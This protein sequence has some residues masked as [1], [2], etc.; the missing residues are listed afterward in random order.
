MAS[1]DDDVPL[2]ALVARPKDAAPKMAAADS[3]DDDLTLADMMSKVKAKNKGMAE[4]A[5]KDKV[6]KAR[7]AD[8]GSSSSAAPAKKRSRSTEDVL[9]DLRGS[10]KKKAKASSGP[11]SVAA[12]D[13]HRVV[14]SILKRWNYCLEPWPGAEADVAPANNFI[15]CGFRGLHVGVKG[16]ALGT[17]LDK[18]NIKSGRAPTQAVLLQVDMA[19]LKQLLLAGLGKQRAALDAAK[20]SEASSSYQARVA[21]IDQESKSVSNIKEDKAERN[22][23]KKR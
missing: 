22:F 2:A 10:A 17:I 3:D 23:A 9:N 1:D 16:D 15:T 13:K 8:K 19:V 21:E 4:K 11:V 5:E 7:K 18:R 12:T 20:A 14:E 6:N